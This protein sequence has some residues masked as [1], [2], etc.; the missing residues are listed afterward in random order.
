M[1]LGMVRWI[2]ASHDLES[3]SDLKAE[4]IAEEQ[5]IFQTALE[6]AKQEMVGSGELME[7]T[8]P[9]DVLALFGVYRMILEDE[10]LSAEIS[11]S[12]ADGS[13]AATALKTTIYAHARIFEKM[14]DPYLRAKAEDI[15]H[16]GN[17]IYSHMK[18][19]GSDS[20]L[21]VNETHHFD[22]ER[23]QFYQCCPGTTETFGWPDLSRWLR[24]FSHSYSG[25]CPWDTSCNGD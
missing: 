11:A 25:K 2:S 21:S 16:I 19:A 8:L 17:R 23:Y 15:R 4:D 20:R 18:S 7:K 12:I 22:G 10:S 24:A 6:A 13:S 1:A 9:K 5:R 3:V 14:E